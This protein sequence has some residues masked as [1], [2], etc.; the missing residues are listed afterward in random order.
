MP[1][2]ASLGSAGS[3][4]AVEAL[5]AG[6]RVGRR[7]HDGVVEDVDLRVHADLVGDVDR[8]LEA[9][10]HVGAAD[11]LVRARALRVV[12]SERFGSDGCSAPDSWG[13]A[14]ER[15]GERR[16]AVAGARC[17][18]RVEADVALAQEEVVHVVRAQ[19]QVAVELED[20]HAALALLGVAATAARGRVG[21]RPPRAPPRRGLLPFPCLAPGGGGGCMPPGPPKPPGPICASAAARASNSAAPRRCLD[22]QLRGAVSRARTPRASAHSSNSTPP[23]AAGCRNATSWP[24]APGRGRLVDQANAGRLERGQRAGEIVDLE[25]DVVQAGAAAREEA[26]SAPLPA[27]AH[28][29]E[30]ARRRRAAAPSRVQEGD[31]G[32]L[33]RRRARARPSRGRTG[34]RG[35]APAASRSAT[36]MAT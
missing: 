34:R 13:P 6:Q 20:L 26:A 27:G 4:R 25:A 16:Q 18:R 31:V 32:R 19:A 17:A 10:A 28:D 15:H 21:A 14:L 7:A 5:D 3:R 8:R 9:E 11:V 29:L 2:G 24:R 23:V 12:G 22:A 1:P 30:A 33:A 35:C 36:A